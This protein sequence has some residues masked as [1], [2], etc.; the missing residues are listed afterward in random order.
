MGQGF[1]ILH[2]LESQGVLGALQLLQMGIA[3]HQGIITGLLLR[4]KLTIKH[5]PLLDEQSI[6]REAP[7]CRTTLFQHLKSI[8]GAFQSTENTS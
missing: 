1:P 6:Y 5:L 2:P 8:T 7:F 3:V 4:Q